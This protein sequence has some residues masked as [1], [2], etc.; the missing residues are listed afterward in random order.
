MNITAIMLLLRW[1]Y[2][3]FKTV[4]EELSVW[5]LSDCRRLKGDG[6]GNLA[7]R[8]VTR[9]TVCAQMALFLC[10]SGWLRLCL[11]DAY[12]TRMVTT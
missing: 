8:Y 9:Y 3:Q 4:F 6:F 10:I 2:R 1:R 12:G 7:L 11:V 5:Q